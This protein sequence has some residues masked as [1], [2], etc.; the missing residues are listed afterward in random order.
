VETLIKGNSLSPELARE[1]GLEESVLRRIRRRLHHQSMA[2]QAWYQGVE[3]EKRVRLRLFGRRLLS[4]L[5]QQGSLRPRRR[6]VL[7]ESYLLGREYAAEMAGRSLPL[8][9][10]VEAFFFFRTM[11]LDLAE[12]RSWARI[13]ELADQVLIGVIESYQER[14]LQPEPAGAAR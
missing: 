7:A 6:Q 4:L 5:V 10:T 12:P 2:G 1:G 11:V 3:A 8:K 9:E 14:M 13:L